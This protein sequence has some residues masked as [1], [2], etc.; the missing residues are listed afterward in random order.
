MTLS[1]GTWHTGGPRLQSQFT[2][3]MSFFTGLCNYGVSKGQRGKGQRWLADS[4]LVA[5]HL[6]ASFNT[7]VTTATS[8]RP[9]YS[10]GWLIMPR[11]HMKS[12]QRN[13]SLVSLL[14]L[15]CSGASGRMAPLRTMSHVMLYVT[16]R[17]DQL[18]LYCTKAAWQ[19]P[20][21][22]LRAF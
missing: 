20:D 22:A 19:L 16:L 15:V 17:A 9:Q 8:S 18:R 13:C 3:Q 7:F 1:A 10:K 11:A 21:F 12:S 2:S 5:F 4:H 14:T 6:K